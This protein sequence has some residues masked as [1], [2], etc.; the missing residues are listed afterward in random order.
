MPGAE[1]GDRVSL[2][3]KAWADSLPRA[4]ESQWG[5]AG[6]EGLFGRCRVPSPAHQCHLIGIMLKLLQGSK[7][8]KTTA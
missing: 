6:S 5:C 4:K 2:A 3:E 1:P 8:V 7:V